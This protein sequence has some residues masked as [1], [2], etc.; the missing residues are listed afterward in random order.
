[1]KTI[2]LTADSGTAIRN[3]FRTDVIT[4]LL[5]R[6]DLRLVLFTP[7]MDQEFRKEIGGE[8]VF[9]E[10]LPSWKPNLFVNLLRSLKKDV[11]SQKFDLARFRERRANLRGQI[12][13][14]ILFALFG[15]DRSPASIDRIMASLDR[16]ET[17]FTPE[18]NRTV[19]EKYQ[20]DLIVYSTLYA[21]NP[22]LEIAAQQ[23]KIKSCAYIMSWDNP[24]TKGPF[25]VRPDRAIVWNEIMKEELV[26]FHELPASH[27]C[28]SG[29][30]Q[31][32]IYTR[33]DRYRSRED[34]FARWKLDPAKKLI[35]YTT[36]SAGLFP[37]EHEVVQLLRNRLVEGALRDQAQL[38]VRL[39][40]KADPGLFAR[41]EGVENL[42]IQHPGRR[43]ATDDHWNPTRDD[44]LDLGETIFHSDVMVNIASTLTIEAACFNKPVVNFAF[45]GF[46]T[47]P[48]ER[49][50]R[51][52]YDLN[53]YKKIM[54]TGGV[55]LARDIDEGMQFIQRYLDQPQL[56]SAGR[57]RIRDEQ[58]YRFD[59]Q[60]GKRIGNY[61]L[62]LLDAE[63][64]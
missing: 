43:G 63:K 9:F 18:L 46:E 21:K 47:L 26:T 13:R 27:V 4:T 10:L 20:P 5:A 58:C 31:F 40:P 15:G 25:P 51:R 17:R 12:S 55:V 8:N 53:H 14:G 33:T 32:D 37:S 11:W 42:V 44:M 29:P 41:F 30:P 19:Y 48:Y 62:E 56:E 23:R 52:F 64:L 7:L 36:G 50:C 59:G 16:L 54:E 45:D 34:F 39:H 22:S 35:V 61:I 49:S 24:T 28:V 57:L 38:L 3:L 60:A 2:F 6:Q 1:M